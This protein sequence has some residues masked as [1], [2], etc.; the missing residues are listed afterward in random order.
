MSHLIQMLR[1]IIFCFSQRNYQRY[2]SYY[3]MIKQ[4][5]PSEFHQFDFLQSLHCFL[6]LIH[7]CLVFLSLK[8]D[9]Q[10][11]LCLKLIPD[12]IQSDL[13]KV[14]SSKHY[15]NLIPSNLQKALSSKFIPDLIQSNLQKVLSSKHYQNLIPSDLQRVLSLKFIPN[16]IQGIHCMQLDHFSVVQ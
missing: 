6:S 14:L 15:P 12:L 1:R 4:Y 2:L 13:Q 8:S 3:V 9:L 5:Y 7:W 16:L 11:V 10:R